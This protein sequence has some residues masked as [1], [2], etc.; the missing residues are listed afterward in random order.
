VDA[1]IDAFDPA[2]EKLGAGAFRPFERSA[3][4]DRREL[5][6]VALAAHGRRDLRGGQD[7]ATGLAGVLDATVRATDQ[8]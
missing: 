6:A 4:A 1:V 8:T 5:E 7:L 2:M 3:G